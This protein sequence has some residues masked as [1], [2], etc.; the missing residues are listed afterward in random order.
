M[1]E[2]IDYIE[3]VSLASFELGRSSK[4]SDML[5]AHSEYLGGVSGTMH[6]IA[7]WAMCLED[8]AES[9][10]IEWGDQIEWPDAICALVDAFIDNPHAEPVDVIRAILE[11]AGQ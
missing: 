10:G 9:M 4:F 11:G 3:S 7:E 6:K 5:G 1:P 8:Q 2:K